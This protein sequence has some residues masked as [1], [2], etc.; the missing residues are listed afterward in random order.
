MSDDAIPA[1]TLVV[2]RERPGR[3]RAEILMVERGGMAFA[4]GAIVF[5][6][7]RIDAADRALAAVSATRRRGADHRDPRNDRGKRRCSPA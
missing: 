5:P 2:W 4:G 3:R 1:A 6:G 7:G